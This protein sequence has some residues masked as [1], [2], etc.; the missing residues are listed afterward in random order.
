[1]YS[2]IKQGKIKF[3]K[4]HD[5]I[6]LKITVFLSPMHALIKQGKD[7]KKYTFNS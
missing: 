7:Y 5:F 1:M 2:L 4:Y 6:L 3:L